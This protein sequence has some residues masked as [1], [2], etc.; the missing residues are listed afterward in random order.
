MNQSPVI[1]TVTI[2]S[3][4]SSVLL[5]ECD[6]FQDKELKVTRD[7]VTSRYGWIDAY[8]KCSSQ[9]GRLLEWHTSIPHPVDKICNTL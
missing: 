5:K 9:H 7:I 8:C 1:K 3:E 4:P 6:A 2:K